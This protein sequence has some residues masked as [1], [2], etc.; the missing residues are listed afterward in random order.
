MLAKALARAEHAHA[1][2]TR[3]SGEPYIT[4]V[5]AVAGILA[6]LNLDTE[7]LVAALLHDVIEDT[8]I[9]RRDIEV[10]FSPVVARLVD[11][12]TK[13][14]QVSRYHETEPSGKHD[15]HAESVRKLLLAMVE[16]VRVVLIKLADRLH[17][18]RTLRHLDESRQR[19]IACETLEIYAPLANRLGIWQVKWELEDLSLRYT[20]GNSYHRIAALL[21][22]R[23][24][25]RERYIEK[26]VSGLNRELAAA[27]IQGEV[28]GRPKHI[29]SIWRKMQRKNVD[30]HQI[31]DVRAVRILVER[32]ADCYAALGVIHSLWHHIPGEFDDY[33]ANPKENLYRS[34]HTAVVGP[35]GRTLEIQIRTRDMHEHAELGVAAHWR[36]KEGARYDA[37]YETKIAWLRQLLEWKDEESSATDFVDRFKSESSADRVYVLTPQGAVVDLAQGA[38]PLDFAYYIHTDVGHR[39]RGAKVNG[40]IVPLAYE[41]Q[42]G[43][44]VE[45]LTT[46]QGIP[47]R[48]WLSPH[49]GYL[50]TSRARAKVRHWFK[51]QD[52]E[53][54]LSAGRAILDRELNRLGTPGLNRELLA[55][56]LHFKAVSELLVAVGGGDVNTAQLAG[57]ANEVVSPESRERRLPRK[58]RVRTEAGSGAIRIQGVGN[59][60]THMAQ[61]CKPVPSDD[62]VGYITRGRGVTIHRRDCAN[63][64]RLKLEDSERLI[65]V[66]WGSR[67]ADTYPVDIEVLAY[68]RAG[69]LHDVTAVLANEKINVTS[70]NTY[71]D[72]RDHLAHLRLT[73]EISDIDE[74]SRVLTRT[75]KL[76][77]VL[78]VHRRL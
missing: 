30:F 42:S 73:V 21:A 57:A 7:T 40:R 35:A 23:R 45:V 66:E 5:V 16:D 72:P 49:L 61:C 8:E 4:H 17:N 1:T 47:S 36:Y 68:D 56:R 44:Q 27:G 3:A 55:E 9:T 69:L 78:K 10:E 70:V 12:V 14:G 32:D 13:M 22:E 71:T 60:L 28:T 39:C 19:R 38:T 18:M 53:K 58:G 11:G 34:L 43:E 63:I 76:S 75:G 29:Y 2:Q 64:L 54:N 62:I 37:G 26:V 67:Q 20:D 50:K 59:L 41:L 74:L 52:Y 25:D 77:N 24:I 65:E 15:H 33:V 51:H 6:D 46:R 31:F 48:D